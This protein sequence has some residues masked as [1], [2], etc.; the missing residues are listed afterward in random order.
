VGVTEIVTGCEERQFGRAALDLRGCSRRIRN[1][2]PRR[3][4]PRLR[5]YVLVTG[6]VFGLLTL[7]HLWRLT[8]EPHLAWDPWFMGFTVTAAGLGL[9]A[10]RVLRPARGSALGSPS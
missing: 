3:E 10:W 1:S 4:V 7:V 6:T 8:G 5:A 9:W 2:G